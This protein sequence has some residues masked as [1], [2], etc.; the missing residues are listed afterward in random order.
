MMR[1]VIC[2]AV[3][4]QVNDLCKDGVPSKIQQQCDIGNC[5]ECKKHEACTFLSVDLTPYEGHVLAA[6]PVTFISS[7]SA[8]TTLT[9]Y[10]WAHSRVLLCLSV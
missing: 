7:G 10:L 6:R 2:S 5:G 4:G 1:M 8:A 3:K 9:D